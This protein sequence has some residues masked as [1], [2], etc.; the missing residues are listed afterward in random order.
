M[1]ELL[2]AS[3]LI[4]PRTAEKDFFFISSSQGVGREGGEGTSVRR[5]LCSAHFLFYGSRRVNMFMISSTLLSLCR[6]FTLN[7]FLAEF[8]YVIACILGFSSNLKKLSPDLILVTL[9]LQ[10]FLIAVTK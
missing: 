5:T 8:P 7:V 2:T 9:R 3:L 6:L 10:R 4:N 1:G